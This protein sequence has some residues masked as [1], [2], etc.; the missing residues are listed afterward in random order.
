MDNFQKL[1]DIAWRMYNVLEQNEIDCEKFG[2]ELVAIVNTAQQQRAL[3][4]A[5][6][7][8]INCTVCG[9][10]MPKHNLPCKVAQS[11]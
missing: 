6:E 1:L 7:S 3:D 5:P 4:F 8:R 2:D 10:L 11:Q 9:G